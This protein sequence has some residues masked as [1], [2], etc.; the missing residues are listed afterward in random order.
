MQLLPQ[1]SRWAAATDPVR[2]W[3]DER[4]RSADVVDAL[5]LIAWR[6]GTWRDMEEPP[7]VTRP[8]DLAARA[9]ARERARRVRDA[10]EGGEWEE[11]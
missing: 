2:A 11:M 8:A 1:G 9:E 3:S 4:H 5:S 6:L 7:R 10:I